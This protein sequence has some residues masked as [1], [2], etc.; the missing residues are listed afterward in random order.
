MPSFSVWYC[1]S[2]NDVQTPA[3]VKGR[4]SGSEGAEGIEKHC[5]CHS[6]CSQRYNTE[7]QKPVITASACSDDNRYPFENESSCTED[8]NRIIPIRSPPGTVI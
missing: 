1:T 6:C 2:H 3:E 5:F 8:F 7:I 4:I